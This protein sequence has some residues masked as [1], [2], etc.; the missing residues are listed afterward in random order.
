M[1]NS[2]DKRHSMKHRGSRTILLVLVATTLFGRLE[3]AQTRSNFEAADV[4]VSL[5]REDGRKGKTMLGGTLVR[6]GKYEIWDATIVDLIHTAYDVDRRAIVGGPAWLAMDRFDVIAKVPNDRTSMSEIRSM[7]QALLQDR[8]ELSVRSESKPMPAWVL[9]KGASTP[10]LKTPLSAA[11]TSCRMVSGNERL[12]CRNVTLDGFAATL[13][14]GALTTLPVVNTT[15]IEG[16]WD[17]DINYRPPNGGLEGVSEGNP[18]L[19]AIAQQLGLKLEIQQVPQSVLAIERVNRTPTP[20]APDIQARLPRDPIEFEVASIRSCQE[21]D[22]GNWVLSP[23]GLVTTG[24]RRLNFFVI[25]A[26]DQ[27]HQVQDGPNAV[28]GACP[29]AL[30][31]PGAPNW[32]TDRFFSIQAKSSIALGPI[33]Q[34]PR[35][36]TML[37]QLLID[38]FK[39]STHYEDREVSVRLLV[40]DNP[41]LTKGDTAARSECEQSGGSSGTPTVLTCRNVTMTQFAERLEMSG[42]DV[43]RILDATNLAGTW[44]IRLTFGGGSSPQ[45]GTGAGG[46]QPISMTDALEQQLGLRLRDAKRV[47]PA[48]II[49]HIDERPTAN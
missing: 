16:T 28:G 31:L 46:P 30:L 12:A 32:I 35:F 19:P 40:A 24:C 43:R 44:D 39:L 45:R 48:L 41:K 7:L 1:T 21:S 26:L 15:G 33:H 25:A 8:F 14:R 23:S 29:D 3:Q 6:G 4:H 20:N 22:Y 5:P 2:H 37:R 13:R 27:C 34:D 17:F 18:I 36:R 11:E 42:L 38:R 47:L 9:S 49:D 10:N